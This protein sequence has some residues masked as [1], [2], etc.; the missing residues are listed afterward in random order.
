MIVVA[1]VLPSLLIPM[2][3][4]GFE[5]DDSSSD[6][7]KDDGLVLYDSHA[8]HISQGEAATTATRQGG[9]RMFLVSPPFSPGGDNLHG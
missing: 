4:L 7:C 8:H 1:D 9:L 2:A 3:D 5:E 6:M